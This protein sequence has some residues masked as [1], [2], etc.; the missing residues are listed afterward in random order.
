MNAIVATDVG[1]GNTKTAFS[2]GTD[3]GTHMFP[4]LAPPAPPSLIGS[5]SGGLLR[6]GDVVRVTVD[7]GKYLVGP[8]VP[9]SGGNGD[10]G[11]TLAEDYCTTANYA[12]LLAGAFH[13]TKITETDMLVLG[14][15]VQTLGKY[16][17]TLKER[18]SG[19]HDFGWGSILIKSVMCVPQ[20]L[21]TLVHYVQQRGKD[22]DSRAP[23]LII[24]VGYFTTDW[25]VT[26]GFVIDEAR[27]GGVP[28]GASHVYGAIAD[29]IAEAEGEPF[30]EIERVDL[31]IRESTPL[32]F[33]NKQIELDDYLEVA[34]AKC[35]TAIKTLQSKVG[36]PQDLSTIVLT[37]G[38]AALYAP[39]IRE[40]F[41]RSRIHLMD[42][43]C[44]AN[45]RGFL[46][47]GAAHQA[48]KAK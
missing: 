46:S 23:H 44:F 45:A 15:P 14:L 6:T 34:R 33:Y 1:Y 31:A 18:F 38:G 36:R 37:G 7:G 13:F 4:S 30:T 20:P 47:L 10:A 41:P 21:G 17:D 9:I 11:R 27:S 26:R 5:H 48:R 39:A 32:W 35:H 2:M 43:P 8:D 40:A 25:V 3:I 16:A 42:A 24:D 19:E 12:A 22:F 29:Q 28:G